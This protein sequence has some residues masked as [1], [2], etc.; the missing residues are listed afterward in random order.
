VREG[1]DSERER[2]NTV[3]EG[4]DSERGVRTRQNK[5]EEKS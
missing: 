1:R 5:K 2:V 3:R 4:R